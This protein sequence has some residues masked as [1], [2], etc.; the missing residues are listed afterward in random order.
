MTA[1]WA[2]AVNTC[3]SSTYGG[4]PAGTWRLPT[5]K[6]LMTLYINGIAAKQSPSFI[7]LT[8]MQA[9]F[10][11]ASSDSSDTT[12]AWYVTIGSGETGKLD[13]ASSSPRVV[14]LR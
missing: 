10:W 8:N 9:K 3:I 5:Q 2:N 6:E 4:Y 12:K 1:T 13:K 7:T 11:T 14:C